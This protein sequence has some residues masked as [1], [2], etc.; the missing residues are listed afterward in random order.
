MANARR[1]LETINKE[2]I[3]TTS[4]A[5]AKVVAPRAK[6]SRLTANKIDICSTNEERRRIISNSIRLPYPKGGNSN[7]VYSAAKTVNVVSHTDGPKRSLRRAVSLENVSCPVEGE[8]GKQKE[9]SS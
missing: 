9:N 3:E 5:D 8:D 2:A 7:I 6:Q 1:K 4:D